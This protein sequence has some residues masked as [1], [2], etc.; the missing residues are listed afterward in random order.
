MSGCREQASI[1]ALYL[2]DVPTVDSS[3]DGL[4]LSQHGQQQ[5]GFPTTHLAHDHRVESDET[6]R[7]TRPPKPTGKALHLHSSVCF[8]SYGTRDFWASLG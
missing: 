2:E 4:H 7:R 8:Q 1:T 5:G 3:V 6:R